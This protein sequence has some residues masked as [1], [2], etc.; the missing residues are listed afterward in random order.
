MG[1]KGNVGLGNSFMISSQV[2][3]DLEA[4]LEVN[5]FQWYF[6]SMKYS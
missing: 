4:D 5:S 3:Y 2:L 6:V 1:D